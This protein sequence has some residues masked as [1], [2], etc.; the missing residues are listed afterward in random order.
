MPPLVSPSSSDDEMFA[1][2]NPSSND[3]EMPPLVDASSSDDEMPPLVDPS[4]SDDEMPPLADPS[5]SDD[6]MAPF[7]DSSSSDDE[8]RD[9][10]RAL[11]GFAGSEP[12]AKRQKA[13]SICTWRSVG[14][15]SS[16][17]GGDNYVAMRQRVRTYIVFQATYV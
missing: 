4:S 8:G 16:I 14:A 2:P 12:R 6:E 10:A 5:S 7:A 1:L 13:T 17:R 15:S 9:T 11:A 3:D